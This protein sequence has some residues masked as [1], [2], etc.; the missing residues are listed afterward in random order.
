MTIRT[1]NTDDGKL[2]VEVS[3]TGIGIAPEVLAKIFEPFC[4]GEAGITRRFGGLGLGLSV[5][6]SLVKAHGGVIEAR[7]DGRDQGATFSVTLPALDSTHLYVEDSVGDGHVGG[8]D[9]VA[10]MCCSSKITRTHAT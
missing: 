7:S 4:Q 2:R 6:K 1:A 3:D 10:R 9:P 5:A 8:T